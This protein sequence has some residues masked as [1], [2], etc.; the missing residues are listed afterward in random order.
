MSKEISKLKEERVNF[1]EKLN[2]NSKIKNFSENLIKNL[3][4][5]NAAKEKTIKDLENVF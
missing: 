4:N 5:E 3:K 2:E 1:D